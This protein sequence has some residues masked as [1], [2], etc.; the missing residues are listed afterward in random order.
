[1]EKKIHCNFIF[2]V[3]PKSSKF[4]L[5]NIFKLYEC[6]L[7]LSSL[8]VK[9]ILYLQM[10]THQNDCFKAL[11]LISFGKPKSFSGAH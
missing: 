8:K 4:F 6:N 2:Y 1:M 7:R 3:K 10:Y 5:N 11:R 9:I